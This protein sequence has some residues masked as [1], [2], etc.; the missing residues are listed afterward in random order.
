MGK[1]TEKEIDADFKAAYAKLRL[2]YEE[3]ETGKTVARSSFWFIKDLKKVALFLYAEELFKEALDTLEAEMVALYERRSGKKLTKI[4]KG[5]VA[6]SWLSDSASGHS[7]FL[8]QSVLAENELQEKFADIENVDSKL[9]PMQFFGNLTDSDFAE[10]IRGRH[11]AVDYVGGDHGEYTHRIQWYC[12][13]KKAGALE[14]ACRG[15]GDKTTG[16]L[17][18]R[19]GPV[20][21]K[22]FDR[23]DPSDVN[24]FR[25]PEKLNLY[26][27]KPDDAA[28]TRW[29]LLTGFMISRQ[30]ATNGYSLQT[31]FLLAAKL[32][33]GLA[34]TPGF[35]LMSVSDSKAEIER[36]RKLP[37]TPLT[38]GIEKEINDFL[39]ANRVMTG[40]DKFY[41]GSQEKAL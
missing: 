8:L 41:V 19:S 5:V 23:T 10:N 38:E 21:L 13:S 16:E 6:Q 37:V 14:L 15:N 36:L 18:Q 20:W 22:V 4:Q 11:L 27:G 34:V 33:Y 35:L 32:A 40:R 7:A 30:V 24:D 25:R 1:P 29:P 17:F 2:K 3:P 12:I 28:K 9:H 39:D 26:L 31:K